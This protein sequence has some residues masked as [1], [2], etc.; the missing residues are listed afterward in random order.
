VLTWVLIAGAVAVV[1]AKRLYGEPVN[2]RDLAVP[3]LVLLGIGVHALTKVDPTAVD[4]VWLA[5]GSLVGLGLGVVRSAT[6]RLFR[7]DGVLWQRYTP[8]TLLVWL[9]SF[10]VSVALGLA[11]TA[12]GAQADARPLTLSIGIGLLGELIPIGLRLVKTA[13]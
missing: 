12:S 4:W 2:V 3:P 9:G 5:A 10:A 8:W 6:V 13:A 1:V 7:R 11:A